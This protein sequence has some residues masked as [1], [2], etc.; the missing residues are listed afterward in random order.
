MET[1]NR[2]DILISGVGGQGILLCSDILGEASIYE[3]LPVKGAEVHGMAQR[4]GSV[5]AHVRIG[6]SYG[7]MIPLGK[8]DILLAME[9]LEGARYSYY[10]KEGG[11]AVVNTRRIPLLGEEYDIEKTLSIIREKTSDI[12][13]GDFFNSVQKVSSGKALNIFMLGIASSKIPLKKESLLLAIEKN[14]KEKFVQMNLMAFE[15]GIKIGT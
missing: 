14:V 10:L 9:P 2:C 1:K 4:G 11:F 13:A 6:C 7:P 5:E 8:A 12:I 3:N 15:E